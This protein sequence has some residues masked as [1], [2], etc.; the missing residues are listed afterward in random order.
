MTARRYRRALAV[1]L[2][3]LATACAKQEGDGAEVRALLDDTLVQPHRFVYVETTPAGQETRVQGVVEDDFRSEARLDVD[4]RPVLE[5]VVS[6][7]VVAVRFL[8]PDALGRYIDKDVVSDVDTASDL[9]GVDVFEALQSRQ[10]VADPG[11]APPLLRSVDDVTESGIDP[12]SDAGQML[13]R[14]RDLT[15]IEAGGFVEYNPNSV[16]PTYRA[17]EDPFP[18]PEDGADIT[19]YDLPQPEFPREVGGG[20]RTVPGDAFFRKFSVYVRDGVVVRVAE[21]VGLTPSVLDDF[22]TYMRLLITDGAPPEVR[23][24]FLTTVDRLEGD[25]LGQFLLEALNTVRDLQGD[26]PVR[27]RTATYELLDIG[28]RTLRVQLPE[29]DPIE[30]DLA[31]LVNLGVKPAVEPGS[32]AGTGDAEDGTDPDPAGGAAAPDPAD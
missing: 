30:A 6:D 27:F 15:F 1:G 32:P 20:A 2:L 21:A 8:R 13:V 14:A 17:D 3:L 25:E 29:E 9:E 26:P 4:G 16:S 23:E 12:F 19:R 18:Q 10:W 7:D 22:E 28:D 11:G 31:V 5:R 24:A